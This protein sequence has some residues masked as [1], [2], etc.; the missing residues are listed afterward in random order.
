MPTSHT[1]ILTFSSI[2]TEPGAMRS[3]EAALRAALLSEGL[4]PCGILEVS[5]DGQRGRLVLEGDDTARLQRV[6]QPVL[7]QSSLVRH[8]TGIFQVLMG[9]THDIQVRALKNG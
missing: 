7:E 9:R 3:L 6:V 2:Q 8:A 1:L 5:H 4:P